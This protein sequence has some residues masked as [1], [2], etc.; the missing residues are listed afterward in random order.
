MAGRKG[1]W[2]RPGIVPQQRVAGS[3]QLGIDQLVNAIA[4]TLGPLSR[5][6]LNEPALRHKTP[7]LL[8]DGATIARRLIMLP[9]RNE[10]VGAM[11]LRQML[12]RVRNLAGDGTATAAVLFQAIYNEGVRYL[13]SGGN[14]MSLRRHLE[15][16]AGLLMDELDRMTIQLEPGQSLTGLAESVCD[17]PELAQAIGA[18]FERAGV[19]HRIDLRAGNSRDVEYEFIE[20]HHWEGGVARRPTATTPVEEISFAEVPVLISDFEVNDPQELIPLLQLMLS[21]EIKS[22]ILVVSSISEKVLTFLAVPANRERAA[23]HAVRSPTG[24]DTV[25]RDILHDIASLTGG[26]VL[27]KQ[28]GHSF[29]SVHVE[30][31]GW[32]RHGWADKNYFSILAGKGDSRE[33]RRRA[34]MLKQSYAAASDPDERKRLHDRLGRLMNGQAVLWVGGLSQPVIDRRKALASKTVDTLRGALLEGVVPGGGAAL[35]NCRIALETR[36][37]QTQDTDERAAYA[38]LLRA[39]EAPFRT[40]T[41]NAGLNP[42]VH[43]AALT[44]MGPEY[45]LDLRQGEVVDMV[46]AGI[47]DSAAALKAAVRGAVHSAALALTIDVIVHRAN[48]PTET[49]P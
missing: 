1:Q 27:V 16:G 29:E 26:R 30:D 17:D 14:A 15:S 42:A 32:L 2:Q 48:P 19:Y 43:L 25:H 5:T 10:D 3:L 49:N 9:D 47:F 38:M 31:F 28:A 44:E 45:G 40:L 18:V 13:A 6:V 22:L 4:P 24:K 7:E 11:Y 8:D 20:G 46:Q 12:W 23:V 34:A 33:L 41:Q 39:V 36:L 35:L 37:S 21:E